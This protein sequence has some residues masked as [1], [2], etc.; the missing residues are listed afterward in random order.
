[1]NGV[2]GVFVQPNMDT[3]DDIINVS[4]NVRETVANFSKILPEPMYIEEAFNG[5]DFV[6]PQMDVLQSNA[7][8][9]LL[10]VTAF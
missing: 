2:P 3:S 1:M 9:G 8:V 10:I 5:G 7:L 4:A 6:Q